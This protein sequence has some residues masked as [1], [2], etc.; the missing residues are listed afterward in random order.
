MPSDQQVDLT[1]LRHGPTDW[2]E[3]GRI[4]GRTDRPLSG[5]GRVRVRDWRLPA[6]LRDHRWVASPLA[7]ARETAALLG[8]GEAD[9]VPELIEANWGDWEGETLGDLRDRFG[10]SM[11]SLEAQGLD[12]SLI[13]I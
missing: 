8:H 12:L 10:E 11:T 13:H 3:A 4:Q 6:A 9:I 1:L 7:R 2:N 5:A